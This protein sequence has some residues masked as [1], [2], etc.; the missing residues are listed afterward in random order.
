MT[1]PRDS[2]PSPRP[3]ERIANSGPPTFD[4]EYIEKIIKAKGLRECFVVDFVESNRRFGPRLMIRTLTSHVYGGMVFYRLFQRNHW[5]LLRSHNRKGIF[6]IVGKI[7]RAYRWFVFM[8]LQRILLIVFRS[9]ISEF[10]EIYPGVSATFDNLGITAGSCVCS[11]VQIKGRVNLL[12]HRD[13]SP[14]IREDAQLNTGCVIIGCVTVGANA[15]VGANS[16]V[17]TNVPDGATV[18]GNPAKVVFRRPTDSRT[19]S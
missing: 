14:T 3:T 7:E 4:L 13:H 6:K 10:A 2:E 17:I 18:I 1:S 8:L 5:L 19:D 15:T 16:V 11:G 9:E 12:S